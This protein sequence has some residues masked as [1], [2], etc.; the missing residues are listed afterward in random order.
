MYQKSKSSPVRPL[1][2]A[3]SDILDALRSAVGRLA[4]NALPGNKKRV[5]T[6]IN[7]AADHHVSVS[8]LSYI[9]GYGEPRVRKIIQ[10]RKK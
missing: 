10:G 7:A 9:T 8:T 3:E 6:L 2:E 4:E 5:E 1:D